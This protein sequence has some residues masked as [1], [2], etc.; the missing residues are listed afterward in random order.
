M[1]RT[2]AA[3]YSSDTA[4][5]RCVTSTANTVF[6]RVASL[7]V[8]VLGVLQDNPSSGQTGNI[9]VYGVTRVRVL[10]TS[11]NA[12]AVMDK[13]IASSQGGVIASTGGVGKYII[14]R[15][16]E[17]L[18][19]NSTGIIAMLLTHQGSGSSGTAQVG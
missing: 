17:T 8:P 12:I 4:R 13:M 2:A 16:L 5:W 1:N 11:H 18:G 10:T 3:N 6:K 15:A 19:A 9:M 7:G 14:G